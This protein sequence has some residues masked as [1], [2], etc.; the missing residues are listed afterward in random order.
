[1][2]VSPERLIVGPVLALVG[3][4][5]RRPGRRAPPPSVAGRRRTR[6]FR[7][8]R[9]GDAVG[10]AAGCGHSPSDVRAAAGQPVTVTRVWPGGAADRAGIRVGDVVRQPAARAVRRACA[11][12]RELQQLRPGAP[13]ALTI[14]QPHTGA[15]PRA[16]CVEQPAIWSMDGRRGPPGCGCTSARCAQMTAFLAGAAALAGAWRPRHHRRADDAGADRHGGRQRR[17]A[18]RQR[19]IAAAARPAAADLQLDHHAAVVPDHRPRRAATFRTAARSSIVTA[20]SCPA[21]IAAALPMFVIGALNAAFL[22]GVDAV[23]P[24]LTWV[25]ERGWTFDACFALG[26]GVNLLIVIEGIGRYR[27]N[28]DANERR[29]I[30]IVVFTGVPA[31]FAYALKTGVPLMLRACSAGRWNCRGRSKRCCRP[32]S[33]LPAFA[34][35]LRGGG[36]ARLQPAHGAAAQPAVRVRAADAGGA[37]RPAGRWPWSSRWCSNATSRWRRSSAGARCST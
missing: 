36:A 6:R 32:S 35:A 22:L 10:A 26:L 23:L 13:L 30:Q 20:G 25:A 27:H 15:T 17:A 7:R 18:A 24:A 21:V 33:L 16:S 1:M 8:K 9:H 4:H 12:W 34:P 31:V 2:R 19:A 11:I 37:G 29:R 28:P 14:T 5:A 3:R